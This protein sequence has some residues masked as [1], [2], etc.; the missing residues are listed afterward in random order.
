M[1]RLETLLENPAVQ[2]LGLIG[3]GA[4][5]TAFAPF[6]VIRNL[7]KVALGTGFGMIVM[8]ENGSYARNFV[9]VTGSLGL[10]YW[11]PV[12]MAVVTAGVIVVRTAVEAVQ[13]CSRKFGKKEQSGLD[14][15]PQ[16]PIPVNNQPRIEAPQQ[17]QRPHDEISEAPRQSAPV[18]NQPGIEPP[19][20]P[21]PPVSHERLQIT[22]EPVFSLNRINSIFQK[23]LVPSQFSWLSNI[24]IDKE[25]LESAP[26]QLQHLLEH[27][28]GV[29]G[30]EEEDFQAEIRFINAPGQ[31]RRILPRTGRTRS[32]RVFRAAPVQE[33]QVENQKGT[34]CFQRFATQLRSIFHKQSALRS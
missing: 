28:P 20:E 6:E 21:N 3:A 25:S 18:H 22:Y 13:L 19:P 9:T 23:I 15:A 30:A 17:E 14:Q 4:A 10:T 34:T 26:P 5:A 31:Q 24:N 12:S 8:P 29:L 33:P 32:G 7:G 11:S 16:E 1:N 2:T 27:H